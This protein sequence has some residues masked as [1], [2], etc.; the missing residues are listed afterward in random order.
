MKERKELFGEFDYFDE[1][2][3]EDVAVFLEE[4][5]DSNEG[6]IKVAKEKS[7]LFADKLEDVREK[8][9][10]QLP[11]ENL[12]SVPAKKKRNSKQTVLGGDVYVVQIR[13]PKSLYWKVK[14]AIALTNKDS[15]RML[16]EAMD[17][18]PVG[19][20]DIKEFVSRFVDLY[21]E[22]KLQFRLSYGTYMKL[23]MFAQD[24]KLSISFVV[25]VILSDYLGVPLS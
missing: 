20:R 21:Y 13:L 25:A 19:K 9:I 24:N 5:R 11:V 16:V 10:V 23:K 7:F 18:L 8:K 3:D 6:R 14:E 12:S 15:G 2:L 4:T 1:G 22:R 17:L